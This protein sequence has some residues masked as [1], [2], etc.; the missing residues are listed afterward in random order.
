MLLRQLRSVA[1]KLISR[2]KVV[3]LHACAKHIEMTRLSLSLLLSGSFQ[4][5]RAR[6]CNFPTSHQHH[7]F[8]ALVAVFL[9][10]T[11]RRRT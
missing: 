4:I 8:A 7:N 5:P 3:M 2:C 10:R 1:G 6:A 9:A 11:G